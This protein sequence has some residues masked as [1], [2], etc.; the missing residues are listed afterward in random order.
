[1]ENRKTMELI[2]Q[3]QAYP[4]AA[5]KSK[6]LLIIGKLPAYQGPCLLHDPDA[7]SGIPGYVHNYYF[8]PDTGV[9]HI[10]FESPL[11]PYTLEKKS[12]V[13]HQDLRMKSRY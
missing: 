13:H 1:M 3:N 8:N 12:A 10:D 5:K 6:S 9:S 7:V 4:V 2:F 11:Y